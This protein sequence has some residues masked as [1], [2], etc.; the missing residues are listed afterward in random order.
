MMN[1]QPE[2]R[3]QLGRRGAQGACRSLGY[4]AGAQLLLGMSSP[5]PADEFARELERTFT[6]DGSEESLAECDT[7]RAFPDY[8]NNRYCDLA[9]RSISLICSTP[10]GAQ[11]SSCALSITSWVLLGL[12]CVLRVTH[13]IIFATRSASTYRFKP[14]FP[15]S[16]VYSL[17]GGCTD[18]HRHRKPACVAIGSLTLNSRPCASDSSPGTYPTETSHSI[19]LPCHTAVVPTMPRTVAGDHNYVGTSASVRVAHARVRLRVHSEQNFSPGS[20][21][22]HERATSRD[23]SHSVHNMC[24]VLHGERPKPLTSPRNTKGRKHHVHGVF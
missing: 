11:T 12:L 21:R 16:A 9:T 13:L 10:S 20:R 18:W 19:R 3:Q 24:M 15:S 17:P 6:C 2:P 4:S 14:K 5:F 23:P 8:L 7:T 22:C 1:E